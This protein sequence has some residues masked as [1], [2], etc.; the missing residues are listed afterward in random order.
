MDTVYIWTDGSCNNKTHAA[1]GYGILLRYKQNEKT[2]IGGSYYNTTSARMEIRGAISALRAIIDKKKKIKLHCDNI[3]V[4]KS[5]SE[6]WLLNWELQGWSGRKNKDLLQELLI[7]VR[8]FP[9]GYVE[10]IHVKGHSGQRENEICDK[11]AAQGG[12]LIELFNDQIL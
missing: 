9:V 6:E 11:L 3:Y 10:F 12:K 8:K 1:G 5:V 2:I 4:V 7:E